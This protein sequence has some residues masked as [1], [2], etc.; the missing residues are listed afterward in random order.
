MTITLNKIKQSLK[1]IILLASALFL[2]VWLSLNEE[3]DIISTTKKVD[4][5]APDLTLLNSVSVHYDETGEKKY[6]LISDKADHFKQNNMAYF[7]KPELTSYDQ[8]NTWHAKSNKG[9]ANLKTDIIILEDQVKIDR[10]TAS[11]KLTLR[12]SILHL[13]TQENTAENEVLTVVHS[14]QSYIETKGFHS[15]FNT[16]ETL[17]KSNVRGTYVTPN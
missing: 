6:Q 13:N 14:G 10:I 5:N 8:E 4:P 16:G 12:T 11:E 7:E 17:L 9:Q 2:L 3:G 1:T 15:D